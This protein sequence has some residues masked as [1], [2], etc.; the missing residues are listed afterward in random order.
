MKHFRANNL[1][2]LFGSKQ[3]FLLK[4]PQNKDVDTMYGLLDTILIYIKSCP[5]LS[6]PQLSFTL[7]FIFIFLSLLFYY[8]VVFR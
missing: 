3:L 2:T 5:V 6:M 4:L 7:F 8:L 1:N